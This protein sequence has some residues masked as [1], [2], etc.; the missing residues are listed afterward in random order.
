MHQN[1]RL[2]LKDYML[3]FL[4]IVEEPHLFKE[5]SKRDVSRGLSGEKLN[6]QAFAAYA[7]IFGEGSKMMD[8]L[9]HYTSAASREGWEL[10]RALQL[11]DPTMKNLSKTMLENLKTVKLTDIDAFTGR[12]ANIEELKNTIFDIGKFPSPF[13]LKIPSTAPGKLGEFEDLYV[14]GPSVR[15]TYA[16]ELMGG[17]VSPT[18]TARYLSNLVERAKNVE[19]LLA[20]SKD[21]ELGFNDEFARKFSTVI[22]AELIDK[23]TSTYKEFSKIEKGGVMTVYMASDVKRAGVKSQTELEAVESYERQLK[24]SSPRNMY[25]R[26][27]GRIMDILIGAQP[28]ALKKEEIKIKQ[29]R[30]VF[31]ETGVVPD[32]YKKTFKTLSGSYNNDF[33]KMLDSFQKRIEA[34]RAAKSAFDIELEAG[35]LKEFA[36]KVGVNLSMT[37]KESLEKALQSLSRAKISYYEELAK[38][39][40]GPKHGI[41]QTF[42]QRVIPFSVTAKAVTAVTDKTKELDDAITYL[43]SHGASNFDKIIDKLKSIKKEHVEYIEKAKHLGMPVLKEGEVG[44][45]TAMAKQIKLKQAGRESNL[46]NL[47]KDQLEE[48]YVTTVRYPFTGTLSVQSHKAKLMESGLSRHSLAVPGAPEMNIAAMTDEVIKPLRE[49]INKLVA[50]RE[51]VWERGGKNA[52]QKAGDLSKEIEGLIALVKELTPKFI[53][54]EQ[55]LDFDGDALFLHTGQVEDSRRE[56]KKHFEALGDD[57]TSVRSLFNTLFT[58]VEETNVKALSEMAYIF[59]KKHPAEK[60]FKFLEKPY[61]EKNVSNL[62]LNEVFKALSTY[63]PKKPETDDEFKNWISNYLKLN[64]L[65]AVFRRAGGTEAERAEFTGKVTNVLAGGGTSIPVGPNA[66][67]FEK[68]A[69]KLLDELVRRRLWEQKYSDAIVGQLYK[70]HTGQTVEGISRI[71]RLTEMETG[72][73]TGL[74]GTGKRK[75]SPSE[76]FLKRWPKESIVLGN[77]PVQE[78]AARMNEIL[79]FVIQKG[80]DE[81]HA[82]VEAVGKHIIANVGKK[83]GAQAIMAIME[84]E[85]DQFKELW[86]FNDQIKQEAKLRLGKYPTKVLRKELKRFQPDIPKDVLSGLSR[87]SLINKITKYVDLSAVFEELFRMIK[88]QA[89]KGYIKELRS[90]LQEMPVEKRVKLEAEVSRI[91]GFEPYARKKIE[92]SAKSES[93]ISILKYVTTNLEPLY[94]LRTSMENIGSVSRRTSIKPDV[95]I[96][97]PAQKQEAERLKTTYEN[98]LKTAHVLSKS[99]EGIV[100]GAQ[101]G[102]HSMMVLSAVQKRL[103][104]LNYLA[105]KAKEL[106]IPMKANAEIPTRTMVYGNAYEAKTPT[107]LYDVWDKVFKQQSKAFSMKGTTASGKPVITAIDKWYKQIELIKS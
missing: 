32:Q 83:G 57:V 46:A 19:N 94:K 69:S 12:T 76:E 90:K 77:R 2:L 39:V 27:L 44:I 36:N 22:R 51:Q 10:I 1:K 35:N 82:G 64:V 8:E 86:K 40:I 37:V 71:A 38:Q 102:V 9:S 96:V 106:N 7:G 107:L 45:P 20:M 34:R 3:K 80:M 30:K 95:D 63:E 75:Y 79:R 50:E 28:E 52:A 21:S 33:N 53:N 42:F 103:D 55:K 11:L 41:E 61:I 93:G 17:R 16:E 24:K 89:I 25:S 48:A 59:S 5:W 98:T 14:P 70:L 29:A 58:A 100:S 91:G 99:M 67:E 88:R 84:K 81:K 66:G 65:P 87:E 49:H 60:G 101:G 78:F 15:S 18:N 31:A 85:R 72:F 105:T 54:M 73:G 97:L 43:S 13:K 92:E 26:L 4:Q 6:F 74:A 56:I 23:L 62:N 68:T 104:E 47:I